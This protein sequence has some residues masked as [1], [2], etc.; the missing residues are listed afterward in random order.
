MLPK[1]S[2]A[3]ALRRLE[4][5]AKDS[6]C[7]FFGTQACEEI[8]NDT[9]TRNLQMSSD[10]NGWTNG[11]PTPAAG[12]I[13][14]IMA[15][16]TDTPFVPAGHEQITAFSSYNGFFASAAPPRLGWERQK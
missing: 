1:P 15:Q 11:D 10:V 8:I 5:E 6:S 13:D 9:N 16:V 2:D 3:L 4:P 12:Q 7:R 14:E